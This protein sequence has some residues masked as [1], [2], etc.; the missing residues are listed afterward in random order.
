M[1]TNNYIIQ[2]ICMVVNTDVLKRTNTCSEYA[3]DTH[4]NKLNII[5]SSH[6]KGCS[7]CDLSGVGLMISRIYKCL[8]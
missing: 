7:Q 4:D 5:I 3:L 1:C 6:V 2:V 8:R